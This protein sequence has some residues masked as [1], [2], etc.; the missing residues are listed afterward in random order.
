MNTG[1]ATGG[2]IRPRAR[3][4]LHDNP[5]YPGYEQTAAQPEKD[6]KMQFKQRTLMQIVDMICGNFVADKSLFVYRSSSRLSEFFMDCDTD[7]VHDGSTRQAWVAEALRAILAEPQPGPNT[8][9]DTFARVIERLMDQSD[10]QNEGHDRPG[11]MAMLAAALAR[12]GFEPFYADDKKCY[13]RHIATNTIATPRAN[14]HRPF[15]A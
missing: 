1:P 13:L 5:C 12:E 9:P 10:A 3:S 7:Y 14:P 15:S 4:Y 8:P 2:Q 6:N 11:A